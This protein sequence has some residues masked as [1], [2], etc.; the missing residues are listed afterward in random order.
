MSRRK[1]LHELVKQLLDAPTP[2]Q[3][4]QGVDTYPRVLKQEDRGDGAQLITFAMPGLRRVKA[5]V[6][7]SVWVNGDHLGMHAPM[8]ALQQS[9][10]PPVDHANDPYREDMSD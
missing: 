5:W 8:L 4:Q 7:E 1:T 10:C 6:P 9:E 2:T 3:T